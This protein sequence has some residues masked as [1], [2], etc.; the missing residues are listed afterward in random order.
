[1]LRLMHV[2]RLTVTCTAIGL[3]S[4]PSASAEL[5]R[6]KTTH[7]TETETSAPISVSARFPAVGSHELSAA[8]ISTAAFGPGRKGQVSLLTV[9]GGTPADLTYTATGTDFFAAGTQ[10]WTATGRAVIHANGSITTTG[11]GS[12][13]GGTGVYRHA[14]GSFTFNS[15][16]PTLTA[17]TVLESTGK[18][19]Y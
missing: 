17:P 12:Y 15:R 8:V 10:R 2:C 4:V 16:Q 1:M 13:V 3:M 5:T 18:I 14:R 19:S 11:K 7:F 9:T 6:I